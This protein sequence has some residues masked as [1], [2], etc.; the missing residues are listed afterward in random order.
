MAALQWKN[1][2]D[3]K[4]VLCI[5]WF[6]F[7]FFVSP[8]T[9]LIVK[10][11]FKTFDMLCSK[12][13]RMKQSLFHFSYKSV[14]DQLHMWCY[15][16]NVCE[17]HKSHKFVRISQISQM[18]ANFTNLTNV[19][20]FHKSHKCV[21]ISQISQMYANFTNLTNVC[22]FHKSHKCVRISQIS[23]MYANFTNLTNVC[24]FH[25]SH[26]CVRISQISQMYA[27]FTNLTNVCEFHKSHRRVWITNS[28]WNFLD[29]A[30]ELKN[31]VEHVDDGDTNCNW[32]T[33]NGLQR[34]GKR[35][36]IVGKSEDE[37]RPSKLQ[38]FCDRPEY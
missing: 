38:H 11:A 1:S 19:C 12:F 13:W 29:L 24:E 34:L 16:T 36:G 31:A 14:L 30:R 23:Q 35:T 26:K 10:K 6:Y 25:K 2:Y 22:E 32:C 3:W 15:L 17:F 8:E 18:Y 21:R 27:N 9:S 4:K 37:S 5:V 33:W 7:I 28:M 20:E